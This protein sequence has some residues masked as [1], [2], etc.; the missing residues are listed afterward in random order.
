MPEISRF[1][2]MVIQMYFMDH[3]SPHFHVRGSVNARV[4]ITPVAV[5]GGNLTGRRLALVAEWATLHQAELQEN[6]DRLR[7]GRP[8]LRIPPLE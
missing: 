3:V 6:W 5:V 1:F 8:A 7:L 4:S 2:G